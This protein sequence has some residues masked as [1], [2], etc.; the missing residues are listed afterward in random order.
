MQALDVPLVSWFW[1][2][3]S[4]NSSLRITR[5]YFPEVTG[6]FHARCCE[7]PGNTQRNA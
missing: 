4:T 3:L 6:V 7:V 2:G 5:F 1:V